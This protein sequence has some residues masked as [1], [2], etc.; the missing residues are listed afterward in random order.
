[1]GKIMLEKLVDL[2]Y[3]ITSTQQYTQKT[4]ILQATYFLEHII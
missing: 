4:I 3:N 2:R 1:M